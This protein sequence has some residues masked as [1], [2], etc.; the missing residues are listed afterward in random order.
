MHTDDGRE[1]LRGEFASM[2][3]IFQA[4]SDFDPTPFVVGI[5]A[6]DRDVHFFL[7]S[8]VDMTIEVADFETLP[9]ELKIRV[10]FANVS[11]WF[12]A[13]KH[14][15]RLMG[16]VLHRHDT[17]MLQLRARNAWFPRGNIQSCH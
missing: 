6:S 1:S 10:P 14:P 2:T 12:A 17:T 16:E 4:T 11:G 7:C 3:A 9:A 15:E 13:A 5:Y 8:F